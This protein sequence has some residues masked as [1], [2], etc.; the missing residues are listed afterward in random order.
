MKHFPGPFRTN[1]D[2][3]P[4]VTSCTLTSRRLPPSSR[5][6]HFPCTLTSPFISFASF[7]R[8]LSDKQEISPGRDLFRPGL[9]ITIGRITRLFCPA[10]FGRTRCTLTSPFISYSSFPSDR[11]TLTSRRLPCRLTSLSAETLNENLT[12]YPTFLPCTLASRRLP[13]TLTSRRLPIGRTKF[14]PGLL[15]RIGCTLSS[16]RLP[17]GLNYLHLVRVISQAP[18]GLTRGTLT[19]RRLPIGLNYLHLVCV[20]SQA[21][22]GR[23]RC[24]LTSPYYATFCPAPF[25]RTRCTLTSRRTRCTLTSRR[26]PCTLTSHRLLIGLNKFRPGLLITFISY[27]SFPRPLSDEQELSPERDVVHADQPFDRDFQAPFGRTR[28]TLT[29]RRLPYTLTSRRL[30]CTLSSPS[31]SYA[32]FPRPLSDEQELSPGRDLM[33]ADQPS[34]A[35]VPEPTITNR[36]SFSVHYVA[37]GG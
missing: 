12:Y 20:I 19:S 24:T 36:A 37:S 9:L 1:N 14:R 4:K 7:P 6:R 35:L 3:P 11:C 18:C 21:P 22:F 25:G 8:P 31:I 23:I 13:C 16:R 34:T 5:M 30:P 15:M 26:L 27:V 32:S 33:H 17:I 28:C 2:Y 29:S 10:P